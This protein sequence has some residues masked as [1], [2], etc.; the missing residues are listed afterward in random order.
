MMATMANCAMVP[1]KLMPGVSRKP[2]VYNGNSPTITN[3][4]AP[5]IHFIGRLSS[6]HHCRRPSPGARTLRRHPVVC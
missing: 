1:P 3:S 5:K 6:D 4:S 2:G